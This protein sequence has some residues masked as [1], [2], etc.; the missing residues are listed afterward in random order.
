MAATR[1]PTDGP[2]RAAQT[3]V[4]LPKLEL[5]RFSGASTEW[6]SFWEQFERAVHENDTLS[7]SEKFLYLRASLSGK[8]A[9]TIDGIQVTGANYNTAIELLK[10][11]FGRRDVLIQEHL[12]QL[13]EL[14]PVRNENEVIGVRR[15]YDHLQRNIAA[16]AALGVKT[17]GYGALLCSALLRMLPSELVVNYHKGLSADS[18][19]EGIGIE[20]LGAFLKTEVESREKALQTGHSEV[21]GSSSKHRDKEKSKT[22]EGSAA[23]LFSAGKSKQID[24]CGF[25]DAKNH[26]T[27][28]CQAQM[29][30]DEKKKRLTAA[31]RCFRCGVKGHL[32]K[33]CRNKRLSCK[34]CGRRH[35]SQM[36]DPTW[37]Q[38]ENTAAELHS[39]AE[40][41]SKNVPTVLLQT[42]QVWAEGRGR[43]L[44]RLLFDGGSQRSFVAK[45]LSRELQLEVIGEEDITIYPFG[46]SGN[47]I[48]EKRR[49]VKLW[50]R[51]QY[52]RNEHFVEALEIPE[53]CSDQLR[54]HGNIIQKLQAEIDELADVTVA[55]A[56]LAR[57]GIDILIGADYYWALVY[58][59]FKK[60]QGTLVALKTKFGWTLQGA[61]PCSSSAACCSTAAVLRAGVSDDTTSLANELKSFWE[62]ESIGITDSCAQTNEKSQ[63][64]INTFSTSIKKT[65]KCY[66]VALPWK[67]LNVHLAHNKA[68]AQKRLTSLTKRL[69][70]DDATFIEYDAAVH[71]YLEQGFA[72]RLPPEEINNDENR[73]Y[74]MPHRAVFRPDSLSTKIRVV[75]DA[76]SSDTGCISLNEALEPGPNLN[77]DLLKVLINFR[78][79]HIGLSADIEKAF[80]QISA[81]P[82][83]RD[84]LRFLWYEHLPTR[85]DQDSVI[86]VWR[87][88]RVPFGVTSSPF[89]LAATVRHHL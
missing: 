14:P 59:D 55:P 63:E 8:A 43:A 21:K 31:G 74:Y 11:R 89:L 7:D 30:L 83:D 46:G 57:S 13:L 22:P 16:L 70:K 41:K 9:S 51:S 65:D 19:E 81:T 64:I 79:H 56:H 18:K 67:P 40:Q 86:E 47:I 42:A 68:I 35:L 85:Q 87:M 3:H 12:T 73:V 84:A 82:A 76:S 23:S 69:L 50:L 17:D 49:R 61:I 28:E 45:K 34:H 53:I 26:V 75:F 62:L 25:C 44:T 72:E 4:K 52:D 77:P 37:R 20:S 29:S 15:L 80:L 2:A 32:S 60:L 6:Q 38:P 1:A 78:I 10:E 54:V 88:T 33:Q 71:Q 36:C 66:E 27:H 48:K 39:S 58:G 5:Q 24:S